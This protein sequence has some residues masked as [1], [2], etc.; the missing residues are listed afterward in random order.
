[1]VGSWEATMRSKMAVSAL[2]FLFLATGIGAALPFPQ[3]LLNGKEGEALKEVVGNSTLQREISGLRLRGRQEVFEYLLDHPDFAAA[4]ARSAQVLKYTV[5]RRGEGEYWADDHK[6]VTGRLAIV[7]AEVGRRIFYAE[8]MYEKG[9]L[10][11]PGRMAMMITFAERKDDG[12]SPYVEGT[13]AGYI[14]LDSFFF[15]PMARLFRPLVAGVMEKR[16]AR[17][18]RKADR[19]LELLYQD[20]ESLIGQLPPEAWEKEREALR[21]LLKHGKG[22]SGENAL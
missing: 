6:G 10:R 1:M 16:T 9:I 2:A 13:L 7:D 17:F 15:D 8:G 5:E 22:L 19:L 14:K 20:P 18:F 11:I 21:S 3:H 4:L 12:G